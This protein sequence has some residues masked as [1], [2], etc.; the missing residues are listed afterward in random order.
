MR[1]GIIG[2][3]RIAGRFVSEAECVD[4]IDVVTVYNPHIE[5]AGKF[6]GQY[7]IVEYT[8][9]IDILCAETEGIYIASPHETH[10][11][12]V[13]EMLERGKHVLCEKPLCFCGK[14]AM[15]LFE[16]AEKNHLTLM[17]A[18]KTAYCPGFQKLI[19]IA[20]S[21]T[22]GEIRDVEAAFTRLT[23]QNTREFCDLKYGGSFTEF[24]SYTLLPVIKLL[25]I[26]YK[27][28]VFESL[29]NVC[30][31]D[32]YTKVYLTYEKGMATA[33]TGLAVKSEGQLLISGTK[34][35]ILAE[36]PWW[37]TKKFQVRYEDPSKIEQ[38]AMPFE[39]QGLRYEIQIF[40]R[41]SSGVQVESSALSAE[42]SAAAA[43]ILGA[44]L[45]QRN[46]KCEVN[47][48]E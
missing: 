37:L 35:Y 28:I 44:F 41:C 17:E 25:G 6:A 3:G 32:E 48:S 33:K 45:R 40:E 34:G 14:Q 4:G 11:G 23:P 26:N 42:E 9:D 8:D 13:K 29:Y 18:V 21:G 15:E 39:G 30:G 43:E 46:A 7:G 12:Y 20:K 19:E 47:K 31:I 24:G 2:T 36:S 16:M 1:L 5:S 10:Y 22:I 38:Y 27:H